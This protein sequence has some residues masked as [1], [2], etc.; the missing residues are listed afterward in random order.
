MALNQE[1]ITEPTLHDIIEHIQA[2]EKKTRTRFVTE[3][4]AVP[5]LLAL[6]GYYFNARL[7]TAKQAFDAQIQQNEDAIQLGELKTRQADTL[8]GTLPEL[9]SDNP[10][11]ATLAQKFILPIVDDDK[12]KTLIVN[13][14]YARV[15]A[16]AD[17]VATSQGNPE[18]RTRLANI[19]SF[20][21]GGNTAS[22]G[23][24]EIR[25]S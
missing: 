6:L 2:L 7:Q 16:T 11:R 22:E 13:I 15:K 10:D 8:R 25:A 17:L 4:I 14:V 9:F 1:S 24:A 23:T 5:L 21:A 18:Q 20:V 12:L 19:Q 3:I